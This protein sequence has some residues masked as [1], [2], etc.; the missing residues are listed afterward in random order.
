MSKRKLLLIEDDPHISR[1]L[2]LELEHSGYEII[3][4][5]TGDQAMDLLEAEEP[6]LIILDVMLPVIDG[7]SI[8]R[9]IREEVSE[10]LPVIML[11][12]R[13]EVNDRVKGLKGGADDYVVKPFHIEELLA[14]IEALLRRQKKPRK[15]NYN[16]LE[17]DVDKRELLISGKSVDLSKTEFDLLRVL[18]ENKGIV[19]SKNKLLEIVWGVEDW[20]NPNVVEVY[21]N[22]L[23]KK[24]GKH[25]NLIHTVRGVGYV[26]K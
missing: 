19:M 2:K 13:G 17:M 1:F 5:V 11:T 26:I 9:F 10:E 12:A 20:G 7:F 21:V 25:G 23:R 3:L 4:A 24:L 8:L 14:R 6:D 15:L 22:Y 18:L 16:A